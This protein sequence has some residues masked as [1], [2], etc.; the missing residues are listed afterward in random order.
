[1]A[2]DLKAFYQ[3]LGFTPEEAAAVTAVLDKPERLTV[4]EKNQL[5]QSDYSKQM[6]GLKAEQDKLVAAQ[7]RVDAE[8]AEWA[9]LSASEKEQNTKLRAD[10]EAHQNK[11]LALTQRVTR[12]ATEAGLDPQ[13]ALEGIE[14]APPKKEEPVVPP[15]DPSKFVPAEAFHQYGKYMFDVAMAIPDILHEH[16]ELTGERLSA[17][18]LKAEIEARAGQKGANMDPRAIWE[19]KYGIPAKREAKAKEADER[20]IKEAEERGFARARSEAA[21]PIPPS[22]GRNSPMLR[23]NG[24]AASKVQRPA[25][26]TGVRSAAAALAS[27]KYAPKPAGVTQ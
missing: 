16:F 22:N 25:P 18:A 7:A 24:D 4:L 21:L 6:N 9:S 13:K 14:Q 11:V 12:L 19:E 8:A 1:M 17:S 2:F 10:L 20:R 27:H 15:I 5:R 3:E 23:V 26:E